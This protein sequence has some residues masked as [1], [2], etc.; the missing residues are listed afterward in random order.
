VPRDPDWTTA[1]LKIDSKKIR[2]IQAEIKILPPQK[3][4][5]DAQLTRARRAEALNKQ[6][7]QLEVD[8]KNLEL[9]L[10]GT[11][12]QTHRQGC[13]PQQYETRKNDEFRP[14]ATKVSVI[15][16][17]SARSKIGTRADGA[18]R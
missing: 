6:G 1:H 3:A 13:A 10:S 8:R 14:W 18:G 11:R 5:L 17:K 9:R 15:K 16:K 2:Q 7:R 4:N 12:G